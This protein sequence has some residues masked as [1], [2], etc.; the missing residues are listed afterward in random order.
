MQLLAVPG[1]TDFPALPRPAILERNH[2]VAEAEVATRPALMR[3]PGVSDHAVIALPCGEEV[4]DRTQPLGIA[5]PVIMDRQR[6]I[7]LAGG[8]ES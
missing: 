7:G 3:L 2:G 6:E 5:C 8:R 1:W 4:E